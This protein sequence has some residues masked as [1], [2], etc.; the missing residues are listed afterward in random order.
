[1]RVSS[2][3]FFSSITFT[4][5]NASFPIF[6][7]LSLFSGIMVSMASNEDDLHWSDWE[8]FGIDQGADHGGCS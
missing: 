5:D 8:P 3:C 4:S 6:A 2:F 7:G 1:M